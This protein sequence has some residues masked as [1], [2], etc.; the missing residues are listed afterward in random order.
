MRGHNGMG[1]PPGSAHSS[2]FPSRPPPNLSFAVD[3]TLSGLMGLGTASESVCEFQRAPTVKTGA[4]EERQPP[5]ARTLSQQT[6]VADTA[7]RNAVPRAPR[8]T[9][10]GVPKH[11]GH[12]ALPWCIIWK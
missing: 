4:S 1:R 5:S 7:V 6:N 11:F 12:D 10:F 8:R 9:A 3:T 2:A